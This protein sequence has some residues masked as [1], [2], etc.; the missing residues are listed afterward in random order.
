MKKN[1]R[2]TLL[3]QY[4]ILMGIVVVWYAF[5]RLMV[6]GYSLQAYSGCNGPFANVGSVICS[7]VAPSAPTYWSLQTDTLSM[8]WISLCVAG[9]VTVGTSLLVY[10]VVALQRNGRKG[11][12]FYSL[13]LV[14]WPRQ[15]QG[16][17]RKNHY[18]WVVNKN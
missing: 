6:L 10:L 3:V 8:W 9:V 11:R 2:R 17:W 4:L 15:I 16:R 13:I 12:P 14:R 18:H 5:A 7:R 1:I